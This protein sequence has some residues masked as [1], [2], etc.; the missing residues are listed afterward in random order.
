MCL[1]CE[2]LKRKAAL[3]HDNRHSILGYQRLEFYH[4]Q[5][6]THYFY[7]PSADRYCNR[8]GWKFIYNDSDRHQIRSFVNICRSKGLEFVWTVNPGPDY[9]WDE[10]D[11][12]FLL[13]KLVM[14]Y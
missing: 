12:D 4:Q 11:Y 14:M 1:P 3:Y 5:G 8:W 6:L 13:N 9:A 10:A 2:P 7:G